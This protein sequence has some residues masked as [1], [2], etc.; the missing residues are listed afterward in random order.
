MD[1]K[2]VISEILETSFKLSMEKDRILEIFKKSGVVIDGEEV[3]GVDGEAKTV[4]KSL[5]ENLSAMAV[6]KISAK[7]IIRKSGLSLY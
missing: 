5:M 2:D 7:Q 1:S 3:V 6:I 4:L